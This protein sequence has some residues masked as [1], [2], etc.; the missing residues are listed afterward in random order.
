[1]TKTETCD[2]I[3][4]SKGKET[5]TMTKHFYDVKPTTV[6]HFRNSLRPFICTPT[7]YDSFI[8]ATIEDCIFIDLNEGLCYT[9]EDLEKEG[10]EFFEDDKVELDGK[11]EWVKGD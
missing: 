4:L 10:L 3:D 8:P 1:L 11:I 6:F 5:N 9:W 2:I 7:A